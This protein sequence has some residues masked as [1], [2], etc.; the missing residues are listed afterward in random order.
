MR[1]HARSATPGGVERGELRVGS[2][3]DRE[4]RERVRRRLC[5]PGAHQR[6][7]KANRKKSSLQ[8]RARVRV[9][10]RREREHDDARATPREFL[11]GRARA[12]N[13][14]CRTTGH[15]VESKRWATV[16]IDERRSARSALTGRS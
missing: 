15:Q 12:T 13:D 6:Y 14:L 16:E 4:R 7:E 10:A 11:R 1:R 3:S 5:A 8:S 2:V 9:S